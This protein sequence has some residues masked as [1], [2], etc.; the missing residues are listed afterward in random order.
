MNNVATELAKFVLMKP[1]VCINVKKKCNAGET[2]GISSFS[3]C[4]CVVDVFSLFYPEYKAWK[5]SMQNY[6]YFNCPAQV[7]R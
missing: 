3:E 6:Y 5:T 7:L 1:K 4:C 2:P